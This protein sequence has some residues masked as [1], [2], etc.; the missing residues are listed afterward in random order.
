MMI[1]AAHAAVLL[2]HTVLTVFVPAVIAKYFVFLERPEPHPIFWL[3]GALSVVMGAVLYV[4]S[5]LHLVGPGRGTPAIWEP[6]H[7]LAGGGP[8]RWLRNPMYAALILITAG[9]AS[10]TRQPALL[11]YSGLLFAGFHVFVVGLEEPSLIRRFGASYEDYRSAVPRWK[12]RKRPRSR[13]FRG[14]AA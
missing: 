9:T 8:Y 14:G 3:I 6:P 2:I 1:R 13:Q 11:V 12:P 4:Q 5:H 10:L 7:F